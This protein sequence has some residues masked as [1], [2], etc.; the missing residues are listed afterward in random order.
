[1]ELQ[2]FVAQS[3]EI[4]NELSRA[5]EKRQIG[6]K[7]VE[8]RILQFI[9]RIGD[10]MVQEV[11][12]G[13]SEPFT[14]NRVWVEGEEAVFD[15]VRT[16]RFGNRFGGVTERKRRCYKYLRRKGGYYPLDE[17]LGVQKCGKFSPFLTFLQVLFGSTRP[18]EESAEL[19]SKAL[20]FSISSTAL[21]WNTEHAG[22]QLEDDP[23]RVI[24]ESWR[25]KG[26]E[27]M[28]VQMDSTTSPQIQPIEGV[29]GRESLR[30]PTEWK[31]C[32]VGTV[33]RLQGGK[34]AKEWTV[35]RYGIMESFGV[36]LGRTGLAMGVEKAKRLVFLSDGLRA[37][38]QICLDHFPGALQILDFYHA[39]ERLGEFCG[40]YKNPEKGQQRYE[41]WYPMFLDGE[42]L[43]VIAEMKGDL[44]ELSSKDEGWKHINYFSTNTDRMHY[45]QYREENLPIGS[46]KVEGSCKY[47]VG[48]R[49]KGSG[50]R[51]KKADNQ[52]VLRAR[53][54]KING[55][56]ESHYQ[57]TPRDYTFQHPQKAA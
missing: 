13:I 19:L 8:E 40:L 2:E 1:M 28:I 24:E 7:E 4:V 36:H 32:H 37:N 12:E 10:L 41:Q 46:G 22:E 49:F 35:A 56:L 53:M 15:Q 26:C 30:A 23:Y 20:G 34:V 18:F 11:L 47:V 3:S 33:Q 39:S 31:M 21:Q 51:W 14:E 16:L 52:K 17:K 55:Y 29:T 5:I 27:E 38:W 48:K 42:A 45:H 43:Q 9:N 54:A 57:P 6:L 50:M 25:M 44:K